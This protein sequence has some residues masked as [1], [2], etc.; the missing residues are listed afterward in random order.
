VIRRSGDGDDDGDV[1]IE[2]PGGEKHL[3]I[4]RRSG[5]DGDVRI[6]TPDG[7]RHIV[8]HGG[9]DAEAH[10]E[11]ERDRAAMQQQI[12]ELQKQVE[13]L[14]QQMATPAPKPAPK[15]TTTKK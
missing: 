10:A 9:D 14:K 8:I 13:Q 1:R 4:K 11:A 3:T 12:E 7:S 2:G 6:E 15:K 5:A